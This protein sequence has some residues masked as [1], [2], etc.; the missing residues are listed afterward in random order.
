[1]STYAWG[2]LAHIVIGL[3][4]IGGATALAWNGTINGEAVVSLYGTAVGLVGAGA[5]ATVTNKNNT[6]G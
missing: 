4:I 3:S 5:V 2:V 1:M 6:G